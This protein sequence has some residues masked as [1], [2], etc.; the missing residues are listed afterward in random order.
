MTFV[1][2]AIVNQIFTRNFCFMKLAFSTVGHSDLRKV[3]IVI[4]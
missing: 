4:T 2:S 3:V 1:S